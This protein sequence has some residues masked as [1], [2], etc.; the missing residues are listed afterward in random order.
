MVQIMLQN[1]IDRFRANSRV[2]AG[3]QRTNSGVFTKEGEAQ[4]T[5]L[6]DGGRI[7]WMVMIPGSRSGPSIVWQALQD[8]H[9]VK[10]FSAANEAMAAA[11]LYL[12]KQG[13]N[14]INGP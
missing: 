4:T 9:G 13:R 14:E 11:D 8:A 12:A 7:A 2:P 3:W 1:L 5:R 6:N 10:L